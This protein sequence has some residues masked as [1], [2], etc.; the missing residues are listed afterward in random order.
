[1]MR[2]STKAFLALSISLVTTAGACGDDLAAED[3]GGWADDPV[4]FR[5]VAPSCTSGNSPYVGNPYVGSAPFANIRTREGISA[6]SPLVGSADGSH[7]S[8]GWLASIS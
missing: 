6:P 4:S 8:A 5:C 3:A 2:T 1:M 7:W